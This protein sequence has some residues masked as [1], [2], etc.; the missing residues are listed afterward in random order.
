[1]NADET[2]LALAQIALCDKRQKLIEAGKLES[3]QPLPP[4]MLPRADDC[5]NCGGKM[6]WLKAR[7]GWVCFQ[8][9]CQPAM[10][11]PI[12]TFTI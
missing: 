11:K 7:Q 3:C 9:S 12:T 6:K 10:P 1:M 4:P 2:K 5:P 8:P